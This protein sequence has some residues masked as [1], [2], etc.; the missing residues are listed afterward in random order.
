MFHGD[1]H[2]ALG[3]VRTII[4]I[5]PIEIMVGLEGRKES[6]VI[7]DVVEAVQIGEAEVIRLCR[8]I[9]E[10]NLVESYDGRRILVV[11]DAAALEFHIDGMRSV[12]PVHHCVGVR[13][14]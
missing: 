6:R 11:A 8:V 7:L 4:P 14:F 9:T 2:D 10:L 1:I 5:T 12:C 3:V 13:F